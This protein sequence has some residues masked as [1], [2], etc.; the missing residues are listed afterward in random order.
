MWQNLQTVHANH[1]NAWLICEDFNVSTS[2]DKFGGAPINVKQFSTFNNYINNLKMID[3]GF[4][5]PRFMW[6]NKPK[7]NHNK[8]KNN[9]IIMGRLNKFFANNK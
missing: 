4:A 9:K 8:N 7:Y 6:T 5:G 1:N 2:S 3:L